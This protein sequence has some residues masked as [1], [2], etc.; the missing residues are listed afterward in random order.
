MT[1]VSLNFDPHAAATRLQIKNAVKLLLLT[2][3]AGFVFYRAGDLK[4]AEMRH[5]P[6]LAAAYRRNAEALG[7]TFKPFD[8][9][10]SGS[11]DMGNV[12][13]AIPSIHPAIGI[14]SLP[15]RE[16]PTGV[17]RPLRHSRRRPGAA[18]R[19]CR[20]GLVGHRLRHRRRR[21]HPVARQ[22]VTV[23]RSR[24]QRL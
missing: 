8:P 24:R 9:R 5:D 21:P 15:G 10:A 17:H 7:R 23:P 6:V 20:D 12:S 11:T 13:L 16:P 22:A 19:G 1:V 3:I 14:D 4:Y 18:R 2:L